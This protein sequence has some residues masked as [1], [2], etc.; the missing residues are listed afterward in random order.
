MLNT[1]GLCYREL[2]ALDSSDHY[3]QEALTVERSAPQPRALWISIPQGNLGYNHYLRGNYD[4]AVPLMELDAAMARKYGDDGLAAGALTPLGD[5][6]LRK[7]DVPRA[8]VLLDEAVLRVRRSGQFERWKPLFPLLAKLSAMEGDVRASTVY[9][10]SALYVRDSLDRAFS[11]L[12][13]ARI[14]QRL[15]HERYEAEQEEVRLRMEGQVLRRNGLIAILF[16]CTVIAVLAYNRYRL[17]TRAQQ[18]LTLAEKAQA[19]SELRLSRERLDAFMRSFQEK[20]ALLDEATAE[21][22]R[23]KETVS[24]AEAAE[25][26]AREV[27]LRLLQGAVL[28]TDEDWHQFSALFEQV[29]GGFFARLAERMPG[30]TP[31]ETRYMALSRL[32]LNSKQ[33]A[34]MLGVGAEAI[35]QVRLRVRRKSGLGEETSVDDVALAILSRALR[36]PSEARPA[37]FFLTAPP[38]TRKRNA[39]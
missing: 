29:H 27:Q 39:L 31:A 4:Q 12:R 37:S 38:G 32:G 5:I 22:A 2:G 26:P 35:R 13:M 8:R 14:E 33:M 34:A 36:A 19:E 10:D 25:A 15:Q 18:K 7:G 23:L 28:L 30:L 1:M 21:V 9:M 11:G 20:S 17:K 24:A 16:L 6:A 3:F